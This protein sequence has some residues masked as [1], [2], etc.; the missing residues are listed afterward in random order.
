MV[1]LLRRFK[2]NSMKINPK[3]FEFMILG[4]A[5]R[6]PIMLNINQTKVEDSQKSSSTGSH[7]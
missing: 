1:T 5:P 7:N 3:K 2:E 6:Q 4:K